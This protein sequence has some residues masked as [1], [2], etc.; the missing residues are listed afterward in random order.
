MTTKKPDVTKLPIY[1][2]LLPRIRKQ[3]R[4]EFKRMLEIAA[5]GCRVPEDWPWPFGTE[6]SLG[7]AFS[8]DDTPQ[9]WLYWAQLSD[10]LRAAGHGDVA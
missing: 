7:A 9:G 2:S 8:W 1:K 3:D 5:E 4:A 6:K 10:R